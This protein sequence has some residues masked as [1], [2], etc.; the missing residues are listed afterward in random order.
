MAKQPLAIGPAGSRTARLIEHVRNERGFSQRELSARLTR[1][2]RPLPHTAL[3]RIERR[4]RR[5]DV[6]DLV[7]IAD[8]LGVSPVALL[9]RGQGRW[10]ASGPKTASGTPR[11][12]TRCGGPSRQAALRLG[13]TGCGGTTSTASRR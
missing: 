11:T 9:Q 4:Q 3:S 7:A 12:Q 8:A 5:C 6:D 10:R 2:G 1:L 13:A